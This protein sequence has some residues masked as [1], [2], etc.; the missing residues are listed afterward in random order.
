MYNDSVS[1]EKQNTHMS[2]VCVCVGG[3]GRGGKGP[4][5]TDP[6]AGSATVFYQDGGI[7]FLGGEGE[8]GGGEK[9]PREMKLVLRI[10]WFQKISIPPP[11]RNFI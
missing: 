2:D 5:P 7:P 1:N 4:G 6:R 10:V 3:G 11:R 9:P 8:R